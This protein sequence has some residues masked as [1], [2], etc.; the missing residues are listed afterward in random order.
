MA[1]LL[2][3][4][5]TIWRK[6]S[7]L[8]KYRVIIEKPAQQDL[9]DIYEYINKALMEPVIAKRLVGR[10]R[11]AIEGLDHMPERFS[12]YDS[13][14]WRSKGI[15]RMNIDNFA[16]FYTVVKDDLTVSVLAVIFGRRD[17]S[18]VLDEKLRA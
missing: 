5:L 18:S 11:K 10:I 6:S 9:R 15:R 1:D 4:F 7:V 13:E 8:N 3:S 16:A 17:I 14:P 12:L 2:K